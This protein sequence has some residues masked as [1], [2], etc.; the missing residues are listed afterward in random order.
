VLVGALA[1]LF[2]GQWLEWDAKT[3]TF[4]NSAAATSFVRREYRH[5]WKADGLG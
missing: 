3:Q 1:D 4:S 5:G 2:A